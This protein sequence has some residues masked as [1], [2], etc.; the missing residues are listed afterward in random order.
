MTVTLTG[1][2]NAQK[3]TVT[4]STVTDSFGQ[5]LPDTAVS[6]NMLIGDTTANRAV[7][8]S[9]V[10]QT[11][12]RIGQAI[13]SSNFRSDVNI[14]GSINAGDVTLTKV[15]VGTGLPAQFGDTADQNAKAA[16]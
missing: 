12:A 4:L 2:T 1:V 3:I 10:S 5:T 9:D 8:G 15:N 13:T 14:N 16:K 7:N 6:V 11:K